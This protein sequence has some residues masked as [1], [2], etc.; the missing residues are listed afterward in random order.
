MN[1]IVKKKQLKHDVR[2]NQFVDVNRYETLT[3]IDF[4]IVNTCQPV[5]VNNVAHESGGEIYHEASVLMKNGTNPIK[6]KK[7]QFTVSKI[8]Y[9]FNRE[10]NCPSKI[11]VS[12]SNDMQAPTVCQVV[13][14]AVKTSIGSTTV[15]DLDDND[16]YELEIQTKLKKSKIQV[17]KRNPENEM[18]MQ[19]NR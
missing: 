19:Q 4:S 11:G 14:G 10:P 16:K 6:G 7:N 17:A 9:P 15:A 8:E 1:K 3:D 12:Y 5:N 18:C 2:V 13:D